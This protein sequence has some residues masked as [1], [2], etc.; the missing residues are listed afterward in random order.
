MH[1]TRG[2]SGPIAYGISAA[3]NACARAR[4]HTHTHT[5]KQTHTVFGHR[6]P[7]S[8]T[9]DVIGIVTVIERLHSAVMGTF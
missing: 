4:T 7:G 3:R 2:V 1:A 6:P 8:R 5:H 9:E